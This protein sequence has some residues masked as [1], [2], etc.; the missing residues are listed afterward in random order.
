MPAWRETR[1]GSADLVWETA[2]KGL[3]LGRFCL[4]LR[5]KK[6]ERDRMNEW[7]DKRKKEGRKNLKSAQVSKGLRRAPLSLSGNF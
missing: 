1:E 6:R 3:G 7:M 5:K 4:R 2:W